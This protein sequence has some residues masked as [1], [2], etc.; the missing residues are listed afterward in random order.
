M[1]ITEK[2]AALPKTKVGPPES[3]LEKVGNTP[4]LPLDRLVSACLGDE[5]SELKIY[6]KAEWFNP[7]GSVKDRPAKR[8]IEDAEKAGRLTKDRIILDSTSG[9]T[10][11]GLAL[12]GALKGYRVTLVA[13]GNVSQERKHI[14]QA[15]GAELVYSSPFE[16]SDGAQRLACNLCEEYPD[17]YV[18]ICQYNNPSNWT[19]HY[20]TTGPE[21]LRQTEGRI[22]HFIA[23]IGTSGTI[24]GTGRRLKE[25]DPNIK[26]FAMEPDN[27][28][29]G[30]EGLKHIPSSIKPQIYNP[31][32]LD[33]LIRVSTENAY[34]TAHKLAAI[35]GYLVGHSSG[36]SAW[37]ALKLAQKVKK[38]VIVTVFPDSGERYISMGQ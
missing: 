36:A 2:L 31:D 6:A 14:I 26:I 22:T 9:N 35:E 4:L 17:K 33:G 11:I 7:G 28:F 20:Y 30:I 29:H 32:I 3:L 10:G 19:A 5:Y 27:P 15:Y 25:F 13:P 24:M 16:G 8:M 34:D 18:Y 23:G 37:A 1:D 12:I 21:I 38:G